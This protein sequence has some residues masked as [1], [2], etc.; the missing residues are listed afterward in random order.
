MDNSTKILQLKQSRDGENN[1]SINEVF[2]KDEQLLLEKIIPQLEGKTEKLK[3][4]YPAGQL[5]RATWAIARL[6]G[7]KGYES[8]RP[9]GMKTLKRGLDKF[10]DRFFGWHLAR[11]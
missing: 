10:N 7:W 4:P 11:D 8:S 1:A 6:G 2:T 3:N 5:S 9:A